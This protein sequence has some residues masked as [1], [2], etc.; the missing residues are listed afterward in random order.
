MKVGFFARKLHEEAQSMKVQAP[1]RSLVIVAGLLIHPAVATA[2]GSVPDTVSKLKTVKVT[3]ARSTGVV[4]GASAVVIKTSE[5]KASPA[6]LLDQALRET[7]FLLVRQNSRG[8]VELSVR[9]SD[10]RQPQVMLD[11]VPITMGWDHRTDASL[12]PVTGSEEITVIRGLGSILGG[13]NSLGGTVAVASRTSGLTAGSG[14]W[15][16]GL[17]IDD[18]ASYVASVGGERLLSAMRGTLS[19]RGGVAQRKRDGFAL[20]DGATDPTAA[21]GLRTNSDLD[22]A[23]A[24][25][26]IRWS[27]AAGRN[28]GVTFTGFNAEKGVPPEEHISAPRFWRYP[29]HTRAVVGVSGGMGA[30]ATPWGTATLEAGAGLNTGRYHIDQYSN[31]SYTTVTAVE[32][33]NEQTMTGRVALSHTLPAL[34]KLGLAATMAD[35]KFIESLPPVADAQY[36][37]KMLSLAGEV[38][39]P[40]GDRT[41]VSAGIALDKS[42]TP[43]TGGREP[44]FLAFNKLGWRAGIERR[45]NENWRLNAS[46]S[47][48]SRFPALR[49]LYSGALSRFRPNPNL[50]PETLLGFEGGFTW[51]GAIGAAQVATFQ[52]TGFKHTL[53][54]AVVRIQLSNPTRF[55]RVNK[56]RIES[57]GAE[58][59]AGFTFGND[60]ERAITLSGDATIQRIRLYD[61]TAGDAQRHAETNPEMRANLNLGVPLLMSWRGNVGARHTGS[62]YCLAGSTGE[63]RLDAQTISDLSVERT[64]SFA[65]MFRSIRALIALDNVGNATVFDIC[66][67]PQPGRTLRAMFSFR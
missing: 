66:G 1:V 54:E 11:G 9:G 18:N 38:E 19:I 53:D 42:E 36:R 44:A 49:E 41:T 28:F 63:T 7:P 60:R 43:E 5:V 35:I 30:F 45:V 6:P 2:Q 21:D 20:P 46:A 57:S 17:G 14:R 48:R 13:P 15:W 12:I 34:A 22:E 33:G 26:S 55:E 61:M 37:Q 67:L 29:Y 50:K 51:S 24:F 4:G 52:V 58:I 59:L 40:I 56:D 10:S 31:R 23:D 8:E 16:G 39:A 64:F 47:Q 25:A 27:N 62:Q 32:R 3:E 65:G